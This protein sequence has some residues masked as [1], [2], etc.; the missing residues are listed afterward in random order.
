MRPAQPYSPFLPQTAQI[1]A[2][3]LR[4]DTRDT[5]RFPCGDADGPMRPAPFRRTH[6]RPWPQSATPVRRNLDQYPRFAGTYTFSAKEKDTETGYSYFGARYYSSDLSI[7][8][9]VDPMADKYPSLSPYTYCAD[10]LVKLVDS[11]GEEIY[12]G[13]DYYYRNGYLYYKGTE[14]VYVPEQGSFEE[15]ALK[16]LNTLRGTKQG[17]ELMSPL[18]GETGKDV[19]LKDANNNP[20]TPGKVELNDYVYSNDDFKSA[21]IYWKPEGVQLFKMLEPNATTDLGHEF[22]HAFDKANG[23]TYPTDKV[24]NCPRNEWQAVYRENM[25]RK[26]LGL[27]Y[28]KGYKVLLHNVKDGTYTPYLTKMLTQGGLPYVP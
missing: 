1:S 9:S 12:V 20:N 5:R 11:N 19:I 14:D 3:I 10:N 18:E 25:I 26:E 17:G 23:T 28:R 27:S 2:E 21:T 7:W 16:S 22:S 13:D 15:K 8:L 24:D 6:R 4:A